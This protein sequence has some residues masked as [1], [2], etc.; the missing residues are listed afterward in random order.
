[1]KLRWIALLLA[2]LFTI[3]ACNRTQHE[4]AVEEDDLNLDLDTGVET[5]A[6]KIDTD[7]TDDKKPEGT[8][9]TTESTTTTTTTTTETTDQ[10]P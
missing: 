8:D 5:D 3:P 1:M 6:S 7:R 2:V 9:S 4:P 10:N